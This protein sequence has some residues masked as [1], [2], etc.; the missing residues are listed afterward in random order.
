M[1]EKRETPV[2]DLDRYKQAARAARAKT[3]R[4][5]KAAARSAKG[6]R[7]PFFG[8][9]PK[10]PL[11]LSLLILAFVFLYLGPRLLQGH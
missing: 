3:A 8:A 4:L 11:L 10:A 1:T 5:D 7:E 9:R 6:N 2:V